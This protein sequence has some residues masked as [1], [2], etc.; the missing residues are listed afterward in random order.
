MI[1]CGLQRCN[2]K[3]SMEADKHLLNISYTCINSYFNNG[4][5]NRNNRKKGKWKINPSETNSRSS[6][7]DR[8]WGGGRC[9]H[10]QTI[11]IIFSPQ[12]QRDTTA[13]SVCTV[14]WM[15]FGCRSSIGHN[16]GFVQN[17]KHPWV[18]S[19]TTA[20][21]N[22]LEI[23]INSFPCSIDLLVTQPHDSVLQQLGISS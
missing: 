16:I 5:N 13:Y 23:I 2:T 3:N 21:S 11:F 14:L 1:G 7:C 8:P 18:M 15:S 6:L 12:E 10:S 9:V 20:A 17:R 4:L 19:S 22:N